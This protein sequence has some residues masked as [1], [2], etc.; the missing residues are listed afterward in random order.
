MCLIR[1]RLR[2]DSQKL[3]N[4]YTTF[5]NKEMECAVPSARNGYNING[6][7]SSR[8]ELTR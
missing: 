2:G 5:L 6:T 7:G 4:Y 3:R 8:K 1:I